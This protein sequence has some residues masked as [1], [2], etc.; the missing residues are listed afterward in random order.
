MSVVAKRILIAYIDTL[1][2]VGEYDRLM[3]LK[4]NTSYSCIGKCSH[5]KHYPEATTEVLFSQSI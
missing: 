5:Y 1:W 4:I 3:G 2:Q